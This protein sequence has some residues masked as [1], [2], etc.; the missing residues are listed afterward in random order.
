MESLQ[1]RE[2]SYRVQRRPFVSRL[3]T[4]GTFNPCR[5]AGLSGSWYTSSNNGIIVGD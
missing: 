3:E 4:N 5:R 1:V 2:R